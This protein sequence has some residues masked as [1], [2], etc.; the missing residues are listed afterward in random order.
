[1]TESQKNKTEKN[2]NT[3]NAVI[4][5]VAGVVVGG[6][7]AATAVFMSDKKNQKK[8]KD[9]FEGAKEKV[10]EYMDTVKSQPVIKKSTK[11]LTDVVGD[12]KKKIGDKK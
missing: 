8:A 7:A 12:V 4:A 10:T 3:K 5:G 2:S 6:I 1:M 9:A 11:K